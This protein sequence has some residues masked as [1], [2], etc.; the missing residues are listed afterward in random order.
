MENVIEILDIMVWPLVVSL[1]LIMFKGDLSK[2]LRRV[3]TVETSSAKMTFREDI[4]EVELEMADEPTSKSK[5]SDKWLK[6]MLHIAS[7]NPRAAITEAWTAIEVVCLKLGMVHG[8]TAQTRFSPKVLETYLSN[9]PSFDNKLIGR[10]MELRKLRNSVVHGRDED[11]EFVDAKKYIQI[12]DKT[13]T[14]LNAEL[15]E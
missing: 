14:A 5:E 11:F 9:L 6:E 2:I 10:V 7:L 8:A 3:T 15:I 4:E 1:G 12:A 13:L